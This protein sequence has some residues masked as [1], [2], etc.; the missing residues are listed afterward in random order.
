[1]MIRTALH[2]HLSRFG[3][4]RIETPMI[5][6][7]ALFLTKAGDQVI[8][9]LLTFSRSGKEYALRPEF[10]ASAVERYQTQTAGAV[11]WQFSGEI[12]Q[13]ATHHPG[14]FQSMSLGAEFIGMSGTAADAEVIAAAALGLEH[15][16]IA[17]YRVVIGHVGL[18]RYLLQRFNLD[19]RTIRFLLNQKAVLAVG[20]KTAVIEKLDAYLI[21]NGTRLEMAVSDSDSTQAEQV[22]VALP[23]SSERGITMGYRTREDI[24]QRLISKSQR[25][26]RRESI[27]AAVDWLATWTQIESPVDTVRDVLAPY[28]ANDAQSLHLLDE[29]LHTLTL[30]QAYGIDSKRIHI[31]PDLARTWDYYTGIVFELTTPDGLDLGGGGRYDELTRLLGGKTT[32]AVGFAYYLDNLT[33]LVEPDTL[34]QPPALVLNAA[35]HGVIATVQWAQALRSKGVCVTLAT[36]PHDNTANAYIDAQNS[37]IYRDETYT[38]AQIGL[39]VARLGDA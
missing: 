1:M 34:Q 14:R 20:H 6:S 10:T 13:D 39:L 17:D 9:R 26:A 30:L 19:D 38:L 24:A 29:L 21:P 27:L 11:R 4:T 2:E 31:K 25:A 33:P 35:D 8:E 5:E 16:G 22:L 36:E 28:C 23:N 3:Y 7:A 37:L 18:T 12:F 32:P 15:I